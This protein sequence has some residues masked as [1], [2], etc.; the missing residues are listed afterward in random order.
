[1]IAACRGPS[2][3]AARALELILQATEAQSGFLFLAKGNEL[4]LVAPLHGDQ[5]PDRLAVLLAARVGSLSGKEVTLTTGPAESMI[6]ATIA[7]PLDYEPVPI[8][9]ENA[10][11]TVVGVAAVRAGAVSLTKP[12]PRLLA[13]LARALYDAGDTVQPGRFSA[14]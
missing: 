5:P 1:M 2:E 7:D 9:L 4:V 14:P 12:S 10:E 3:R 8:V 6:E 11:K 13:A